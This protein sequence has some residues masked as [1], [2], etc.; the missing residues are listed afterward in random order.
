MKKHPWRPS[1]NKPHLVTIALPIPP[2]DR[3]RPL[4]EWFIKPPLRPSDKWAKWGSQRL[5]PPRS[6]PW[7]LTLTA[8]SVYI[9]VSASL[10]LGQQRRQPVSTYRHACR[11]APARSL[12]QKQSS[13]AARPRWP[14]AA[15]ASLSSSQNTLDY[16]YVYV[17]T[18]PS[19]SVVFPHWIFEENRY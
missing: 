18:G 1:W 17:S 15:T 12:C 2:W 16:I 10:H 5:L 7:L 6:L 13:S 8:L 14:A 9:S 3:S 4:S 11:P 19:V